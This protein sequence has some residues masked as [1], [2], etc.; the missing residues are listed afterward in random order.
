MTSTPAVLEVRVGRGDPASISLV[1]GNVLD[2]TSVGK[3]GMWR[4]DGAGVM[5][6]HGYLYYD[7][8]CLYVQS[9]DLAAPLL[10]NKR[11]VST[12]WTEVQL[13]S[14]IELGQTELMYRSDEGAAEYDDSDAT[15]ARPFEAEAERMRSMAMGAPPERADTT[16]PQDL[17]AEPRP[18]FR[19][20]G[21]AFSNRGRDDESTRFAPIEGLAGPAS[22]RQLETAPPSGHLSLSR[23][24][25]GAAPMSGGYGTAPPSA[26]PQP[27]TG[28]MSLSAYG[29][30]A[31]GPT[32]PMSVGQGVPMP[33]GP[34]GMAPPPGGPMQPPMPGMGMGG[35]GGMG[36]GMGTPG[37]GMMA[38][39]VPGMPGGGGMMP[40]GMPGM[41]P[42][43]PGMPA[44]GMGGMPGMPGMPGVPGMPGPYGSG[45]GTLVLPPGAQAAAMN[46][47]GMAPWGA[48]AGPGGHLT[49]PGQAAPPRTALEKA[50]QQWNALSGPKKAIYVILPFALLSGYFL[51]ADDDEPVQR[52]R[53]RVT[54]DAGAAAAAAGAAGAGAS[55]GPAPN[56]SAPAA[57]SGAAAATATGGGAPAGTGSAAATHAATTAA[58]AGGAPNAGAGSGAAAGGAGGGPA[59]NGGG[60]SGGSGGGASAGTVSAAAAGGGPTDGG[61]V[62][63]NLPANKKTKERAAADAWAEG[64]FE[65][66]VRIY[67]ELAQQNPQNP[68]FREAA[69]ILRE[70]L[71]G[72][73]H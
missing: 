38:G 40:M 25:A 17:T 6:V 70:R 51:L 21:G 8:A 68:A 60:N 44:Q 22:A 41:G 12:A 71:D 4:V 28:P 43:Q 33:M 59:A 26:Q 5:E 29:G 56:G 72:G 14:T 24:A 63:T 3:K 39:G 48:A 53:P 30:G 2:P 20:G 1:P 16:A 49:M 69:R 36:M 23:P 15:V 7:G 34:M 18:A 45:G 65:V 50:K 55:A 35:M 57:G 37:G 32:G 31:G 67:D 27:M 9:A 54:L 66:A 58:G 46:G 13:G 19:P 10:V 73:A 52:A 47:G 61:V 62:L 42:G 11:R 64:N